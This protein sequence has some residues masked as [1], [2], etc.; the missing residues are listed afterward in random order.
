MAT[1]ANIMITNQTRSVRDTTRALYLQFLMDYPQGRDRLK[2]QMSFLIK[3]LQY[4][5]E[6]GRQS[7]MEVLHQIVI[8]FGDELLQPILLDLFVGLLLPLSND[9]ST[10]CR[11]M[12][13]RLIQSIVENADDD[14]S[15][16]IRTMLRLWT[17]QKDKPALLKS[18]LHVYGIMLE[19]GKR[20]TDDVELCFESVTEIIG[21]N[22]DGQISKIQWEVKAQA[23]E[24]L[25]KLAILVP[26]RVFSSK[27]EG[28]WKDVQALMIC[29]DLSVRLAA[30]KL[31]GLLFSRA[32]SSSDGQIQV[33][34]LNIRV[35]GLTAFARHSLEQIKTP[36]ATPELGLQA[37]KNLIFLGRHFYNT[38]CNLP[39]KKHPE[40][41]A[42]TEAISCLTWLVSRVAAEIRYERTVAEVICQTALN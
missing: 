23:L 20:L 5:H 31:V 24:L 6:T 10:T 41:D 17:E 37:V 30:S 19:N 29:E 16:A 32:E 3:N 8:K 13:S 40:A 28:L 27:Q 26:A 42:D 34:G 36:D 33:E 38:N 39:Q 4:D 15:K 35:P 11:E 1:V 7:V 2:K 18:S 12:A 25:L 9:E 22:V 14:R 21:Q